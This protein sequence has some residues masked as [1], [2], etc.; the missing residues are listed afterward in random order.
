[1][2]RREEKRNKN[3]EDGKQVEKRKEGE[4]KKKR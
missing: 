4:M 1:M 3:K 2:K